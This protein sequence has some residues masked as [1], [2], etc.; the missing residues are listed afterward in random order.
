MAAI[1]SFSTAAVRPLGS[2]AIWRTIVKQQRRSELKLAQFSPKCR[3]II[4]LS[5]EYFP[6]F[7]C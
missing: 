4:P 7:T 1:R 3:A 2:G 5:K 6:V